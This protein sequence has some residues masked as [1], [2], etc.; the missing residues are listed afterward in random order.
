MEGFAGVT[1]IWPV[2]SFITSSE[3]IGKK[4]HSLA[5]RKPLSICRSLFLQTGYIL[6]GILLTT[7]STEPLDAAFRV[8]FQNHTLSEL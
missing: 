4:Q 1:I 3:V 5:L 7:R 2:E 8:I 6:V